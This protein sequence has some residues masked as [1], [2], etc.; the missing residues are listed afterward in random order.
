M[1]QLSHAWK[2]AF[3]HGRP[4]LEAVTAGPPRRIPW[5]FSG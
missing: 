3:N 4:V 1:V 5:A 2:N